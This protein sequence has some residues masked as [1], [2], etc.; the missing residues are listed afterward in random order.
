MK[1]QK[2]KTMHLNLFGALIDI[3][4]ESKNCFRI[5]YIKDLLPFCENKNSSFPKKAPGNDAKR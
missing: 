2:L 5:N 4:V 3:K 1:L